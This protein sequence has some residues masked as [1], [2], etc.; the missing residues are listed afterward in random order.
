[1]TNVRDEELA[2][3]RAGVS[4][5]TVLEKL[6]TGWTLDRKESSRGC[7]KYRRNNEILIINHEGQGWWDPLSDAKGDVFGLVQHLNRS[8]NFGQARQV[9]RPFVGLAPNYPAY[10]PTRSVAGPNLQPCVRWRARP[11]LR[12]GSPVWQY[13]ADSRALPPTLLIAA[14]MAD[15]VREGPYNSAWFAHRDDT[16]CVT[17]VEV[18]GADFKGSLRDGR[19]VLFRFSSGAG[20]VTRLVLTEAPID[21]LSV[22]AWESCRGDT[23]YAATGGGMGPDTVSAIARIARRLA[24]SRGSVLASAA[25]ANPAGERYAAHHERLACTAGVPFKRLRPPIPEGDWNDVLTA[26]RTNG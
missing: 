25:D 14:A 21:A 26:Q 13:L 22:A 1:M 23:L 19:K 12:E 10:V 16:G 15:V 9:L 11:R 4:C 17:H 24:V 20:L 6:A 5:A 7:L 2:L 3:L 18:R 8:L